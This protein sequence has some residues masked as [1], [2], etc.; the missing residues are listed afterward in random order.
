MKQKIGLFAVLISISLLQLANA[1]EVRVGHL[2]TNDDLGSNWLFFHCDR[3]G[4]QMECDIFQTLIMHPPGAS[5]QATKLKKFLEG[6]PVKDFMEQ[7]GGICKSAEQ[8]KSTTE[9]AMKTG[10]GFDGRPVNP[11]EAK[12]R[13]PTVRAIATACAIPTVE[14]VKAVY[15]RMLDDESTTCRI[16]NDYSHATFVFDQQTDSW[17][18]REVPTGP[19]G[20]ITIGALKHDQTASTFWKYTEKHLKTNPAG[21]LPNGVACSSSPDITLNY[22]WQSREK[23]EGCKYIKNTMN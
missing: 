1:E 18:T 4:V 19:C 3:N 23:Y 20:A 7:F 11:D 22:V 15:T 12:N 5:D 10:K 9:R 2:E 6:D 17:I 13:L 14:S 16:H 8:L 21:K